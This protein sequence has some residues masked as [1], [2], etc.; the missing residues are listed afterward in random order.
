[1][2][3]FETT[4]DPAVRRVY[5]MIDYAA[6][7]AA[8]EICDIALDA[9]NDIWG[10][11]ACEKPACLRSYERQSVAQHQLAKLLD[12]ILRHKTP[13]RLTDFGQKYRG[14]VLELPLDGQFIALRS[15]GKY[16]DGGVEVLAYFD[17]LTAATEFVDRYPACTAPSVNIQEAICY[18]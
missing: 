8:V 2:F 13:W 1:M 7:H 12:G 11:I 10:R 15:D 5:A 4:L 16:D 18:S 6:N 9:Y 17:T 14:E 3:L